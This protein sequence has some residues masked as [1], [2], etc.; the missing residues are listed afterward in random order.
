MMWIN[1]LTVQGSSAISADFATQAQRLR[2]L[3]FNAVKLPF[4]FAT[5]LNA[6]GAGATTVCAAATADQLQA[7]STLKFGLPLPNNA[8][9][10]GVLRPCRP[11]CAHGCAALCSV[12]DAC[13]ACTGC[14]SSVC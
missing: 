3:G 7:R 14:L 6:T 12:L 8:T 11:C 13:L 1:T 5:L 10:K 2:A 4:S 9:V